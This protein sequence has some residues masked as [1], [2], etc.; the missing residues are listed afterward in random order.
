M[1]AILVVQHIAKISEISETLSR[2]CC[3]A[4]VN[5]VTSFLPIRRKKT[6][7]VEK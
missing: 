2:Q 5:D 3:D 4:E 6:V 1:H 7:R